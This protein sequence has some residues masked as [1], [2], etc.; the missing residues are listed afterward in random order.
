VL[1]LEGDTDVH[2]IQ[3]LCNR[4]GI[5]RTAFSYVDKGSDAELLDGLKTELRSSAV[6]RLG[7]V[8][9]A[10]D[11]LG[12]RWQSVTARLAALGY[13]D[14]PERPAPDGTIL[15]GPLDVTADAFGKS[16]GIWLM[17][18]NQLP[19]MLEDF[20]ADLIAPGDALWPVAR[21]AVDQIPES[22]RRFRPSYLHKAEIHTWLA[23]QEEPGTPLGLAV[24]RSYFDSNARVALS[25]IGWLRRLFQL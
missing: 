4:A 2:F 23:W 10:D 19:G 6:E 15:P 21:R 14:I 8:L 11:D 3:H 9:D 25:F 12:A 18:N 1:L 5:L 22:L 20:A 13:D 7:I 17:P 16:V 24:T